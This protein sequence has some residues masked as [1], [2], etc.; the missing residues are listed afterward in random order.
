FPVATRY[1]ARDPARRLEDQLADVILEAVRSEDGSVLVFLPGQA[2]ISRTAERLAG[3]LPAHIDIAPLY[4]QLTPEEQDR[5]VRPAPA[6]QR[7][8]V[9]AT[10]IAETSLTIEGIR[11]VVDSGLSRRPAYDPASGLTT[12]ET[13]PVSRAAADQRR[14]RAGRTAA[15]VCY[16]LWGEGQDAAR[17]PFD[18]PEILEADLT[19]LVLDLASWGVADPAQLAFLDP[20][21]KPAGAEARTLLEEL[22]ALDAAGQLTKAG[23]AGARL[24]LHPRL[25][26]MVQ[27]AAAEGEAVAAAQLAVLLGERGLGGNDIDLAQRLARFRGERGGRAEEARRLAA[28]WARAAGAGADA[29]GAADAGRHLARAYPDRVAQAAGGRGRYRLA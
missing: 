27:C 12:L 2:E 16:R 7:K 25:A 13:R 26:H 11:I 15:G 4:G 24:P 6:G 5:A 20:P 10:S 9:L 22:G 3:R 18:R 8:I 29:G 21:P 23:K 14:G 28:R 1:R 19:G 17:P